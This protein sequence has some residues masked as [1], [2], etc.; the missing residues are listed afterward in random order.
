MKRLLYIAI[1]LTLCLAIAFAGLMIPS[2]AG[3]FYDEAELLEIKAHIEKDAGMSEYATV[4]GACTDGAYAYFAVQEYSTVILKYDLKTWKLKKKATVSGLGHANDMTYNAVRDIIVIANNNSEEDVLTILDPDSLTVNGTAKVTRKKTAKEIEQEKK[5]G[6]YDKKD[7]KVLKVYSVAYQE[8]Q[9]R[10]VVGLSGS[11]NFAVLDKDFK[12]IKQYKGEKTGYTRQGCDCDDQYIYFTQSG[13][14]NIVV[15][16][17]FGGKHVDTVTLKHSHEVENLFHVGSDFYLTLHYYG[18]SVRRAG[19]SDDTQIRFGVKFEPGSGTGKMQSVSVHYG[20]YT[21]LPKCTYKKPGYFFAGWQVRREYSGARLGRVLGGDKDEWKPE[22]ELYD[23]TLLSD[24]AKVGKL[25]P[26]G[27]VTLTAFWIRDEYEVNFDPGTG[28]GW[29]EPETVGYRTVYTVPESQFTRYGYVFA[30]YAAQRDWDGRVYGYAAGSEKPRWLEPEDV[31]QAYYLMPGEE[32][33]Q[34]TYD[35]AVTLTAQFSTA[36]TFDEQQRTLL[37]YI[38][39]DEDVVI[40]NPGGELHTIA[41][42]AFSD[43]A[44]MRELTIP[45]T[46]DVIEQGAI[47]RCTALQDVIFTEHFPNGFDSECIVGSGVQ[48][49]YLVIDGQPL[50]LGDYGG[51]YSALPIVRSAQ[52]IRRCLAE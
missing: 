16:Y 49:L 24:G 42:G 43:N 25:T 52:A 48:K 22:E 50:L 11:Y 26:I 38:G 23:L 31:D 32:V 40:P 21:K 14:D 19:F 47:T 30:G 1:C 27:D 28:E 2:A 8:A 17:D 51:A 46:V 29:M 37:S 34:L 33:S 39:V 5:D 7:Y 12:V 18:N 13:G 36:Y 41:G 6:K 45:S 3:A 4:Q 35:G 9:D 20:E 44:V 15:I 10:Y